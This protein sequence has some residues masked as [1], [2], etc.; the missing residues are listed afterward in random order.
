MIEPSPRF[1]SIADMVS[2]R[3]TT[4]GAY[5]VEKLSYQYT[6]L[7]AVVVDIPIT[8]PVVATKICDVDGVDLHIA[9]VGSLCDYLDSQWELLPKRQDLPFNWEAH[10]RIVRRV[11]KRIK[12]KIS[13][14]S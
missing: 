8:D 5:T 4:V 7:D 2:S 10:S 3:I 12:D 11:I 1:S 13:N 14:T 6:Y 9:R